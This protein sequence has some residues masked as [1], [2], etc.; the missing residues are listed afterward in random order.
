[1]AFVAAKCTQCGGNIEVDDTKEAG[2]CQYCGTA[3]VTEKAVN[4]Y[5]T[6]IT[7]NNNFAGANINIVNGDVANLL[8]LA[9]NSLEITNEKDALKYCEKALE[10]D[11]KCSDAWFIKMKAERFRV[12][13]AEPTIENA[14]SIDAISAAGNN[15]I[16]Y[17]DASIKET[18]IH[19]VHK[20]YF[21][22][23]NSLLKSMEVSV[24]YN[25]VDMLITLAQTNKNAALVKDQMHLLGITTKELFT[26]KLLDDISVEEISS[27]ADFI[28]SL[29]E[30]I[31]LY[32]S[33]REKYRV[34]CLIYSGGPNPEAV[35]AMKKKYDELV[36]KLPTEHRSSISEWT[37]VGEVS[38]SGSSPANSS[39]GGCYIATCVYGSY[40]CPQVW[41]LRRFRDHTLDTTWYGRLFIKGYYAISPT[42]VKIL[43]QK[44]W[45]VHF[46]KKSL[47][48]L[49]GNLNK[50]GVKDTEYMDK[51]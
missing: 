37:M 34:R 25:D 40:D 10:I 45:F 8:E 6:Y 31:N 50:K 24:E 41:T 42:L 28:N 36:S 35:A 38:A 20:F 14:K 3:F 12:I 23:V 4:N 7:N 51:Y 9:K 21:E 1:M 19:D 39:S 32:V 29:I 15:S 16:K 22:S 43:G 17:A 47:D 48:K 44:K 2:I 18:R 13:K 33:F 5:N 26:L 27:D 30:C 49:V 11:V 46:W